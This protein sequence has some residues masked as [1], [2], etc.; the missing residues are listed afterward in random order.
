VL[1]VWPEDNRETG[2]EASSPATPEDHAP[3]S[4]IG[5]G[6]TAFGRFWWDFLVGETPELLVGSGM[7]VGIAALL[8]HSGTVRAVVV[9]ALPVLVVTV[10]GLST[11]R[12]RARIRKDHQ[13]GP[14][15]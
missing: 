12:A 3:S 11:I 5:R 7:A 15:T 13:K 10:L 9:G 4:V 6:L 2:A 1:S 8:V 14:A